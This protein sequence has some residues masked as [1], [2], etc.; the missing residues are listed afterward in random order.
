LDWVSEALPHEMID[1]EVFD[2]YGRPQLPKISTPLVLLVNYEGRW[3][4][5]KYNNYSL[6]RTTD[7]DWGICG[8]PAR[9]ESAKD[10]GGRYVQPLSFI[11]PVKNRNG[12]ICKSG[13]R[14]GDI[15][16]YQNETRFLPDK[17]DITCN[18]ELGLPRNVVAGTGSA[19]DAKQIGLAHAACVERLKFE[20]GIFQE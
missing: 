1:F 7:G 15:L 8:K 3:V 2:H 17:W 20:N 12:E 19:P 11:N 18:I 9:Y 4:Q 6:S 14:V 10:Q 5:S 16:N 13:T